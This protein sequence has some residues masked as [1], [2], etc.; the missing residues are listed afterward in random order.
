MYV[1][2]SNQVNSVFESN[3]KATTPV[4]PLSVDVYSEDPSS[5]GVL[6]PEDINSVSK[7]AV[8]FESNFKATTPVY[9]TSVEPSSPNPNDVG[10]LPPEDA[11][12]KVQNISVNFESNFKATTPV[13]PPSV[14][15]TSLDP[16][17][18]GLVAPEEVH[19]NFPSNFKATTP[20]YPKTVDFTKGSANVLV[21]P[22]PLSTNTNT[23]VGFES[24]FTATTPVYP[25]SVQSTSPNP[26]DV[27]LLPPQN[28]NKAAQIL[29]NQTQVASLL[30]DILPPKFDQNYKLVRDPNI[31][32]T[33][34]PPSK[35]YQAPKFDPDFTIPE[36]ESNDQLGIRINN[37]MK[38]LS[39]SQWHDLREQFKIPEYDFP[40]EENGRPGYEGTLNS[41]DAKPVKKRK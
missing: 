17:T 14:E 19:Q 24:N 38:S 10:L 33:I 31:E 7:T 12:T 30:L 9:P 16:N 26:D 15:S 1:L 11:A 4:Y 37:F 29:S 22:P 35:F 18:V 40:L 32:T 5:A 28:K 25:K 23:N 34:S 8:N 36:V 3:F 39:G 6:P 21:V 13:Y 2:G 20:V 27:G 41:F